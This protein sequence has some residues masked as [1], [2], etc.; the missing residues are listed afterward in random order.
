MVMMTIAALL[1]LA[2]WLLAKGASL[3]ER[4]EANVHEQRKVARK[5][6]VRVR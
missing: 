2:V 4:A 1:A 6:M 3:V 5:R